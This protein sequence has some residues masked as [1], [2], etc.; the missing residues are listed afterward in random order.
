MRFYPGFPRYQHGIDAPLDCNFSGCTRRIYYVLQ[1]NFRIPDQFYAGN[2]RTGWITS[3]DFPNDYHHSTVCIWVL[4][5]LPGTRAKVTFKSFRTGEFFK[6]STILYI[7]WKQE[8]KG[9]LS[10]PFFKPC[11]TRYEFVNY[12]IS[13]Y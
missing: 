4:K 2:H 3:P 12:G 8:T 11:R 5:L 10:L 13:N 9:T 1:W 6:W 7:V